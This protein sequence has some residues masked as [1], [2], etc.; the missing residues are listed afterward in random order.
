MNTKSETGSISMRHE[1]VVKHI[2]SWMTQKLVESKARGFVIGVSGGIDSAL[3]SALAAITGEPTLALNMPINQEEGQFSRSNEQIDWLKSRYDNVLSHVI[4]LTSMHES[5]KSVLPF[6]ISEL[7]Y[8]NLASRLRMI[9]LYA[10]AN[11]KNYL[12]VG[13]GNKVE[14][15]G[16]GFFT[17][18]GD[19]GVDI[20]PIADLLKT[21]V[22][23]MAKSIGVPKS[24]QEAIPTDGLWGDNRSDEEQI[25]ASYK[26][27]EWA[28]DFYDKNQQ[29]SRFLTREQKEALSIY[30][31]R[32]INNKHKLELPP[33]CLIG[34]KFR[35][36]K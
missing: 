34:E 26:N 22:Y 31:L 16:I 23:K 24:I 11:S 36:E 33:V 35:N 18:Y 19:G 5:F 9:T 17:K 13:T 27:L 15:Y 8:A 29:E 3:T 10:F 25:G 32:H 4:D 30:T 12:V 20:S 28:L 2:S 7:A 6:E 1:E 14:D 21:E